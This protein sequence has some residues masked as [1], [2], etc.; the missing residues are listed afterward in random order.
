VIREWNIVREARGDFI[1]TI[2]A[3][4]ERLQSEGW[5]LKVYDAVKITDVNNLYCG[6]TGVIVRIDTSIPGDPLYEVKLDHNQQTT[7]V[8]MT[9]D[10]LT[11]YTK[12][13]PLKRIIKVPITDGFM[14]NR[15][16]PI[17]G[18]N[19]DD[20]FYSGPRV[21][22]AWAIQ[23]FW[24]QYRARKIAARL[25]FE[26][27]VRSADTQ[28][29]LISTLANTNTLTYQA[30]T[31][32]GMLGLKPSKWVFYDEVRH[33]FESLRLLA[34]KRVLISEKKAIGKEAMAAYKERIKF[35]EAMTCKKIFIYCRT[36]YRHAFNVKFQFQ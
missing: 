7:F 21:D 29:A 27:W 31:L 23:L 35:M 4:R 16:I 30:N 28:R 1:R 12:K 22:A 19:K 6:R 10:A 25:R 14:N 18:I 13:Q 20:P 15:P 2:K 36:L 3:R 17:Y 24:R 8:M 34:S 5:A 26:L 9:T 32:A 33:N 11:I